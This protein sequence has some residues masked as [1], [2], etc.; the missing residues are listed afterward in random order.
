M[1][2]VAHLALWMIF[3]VGALIIVVM[4]IANARDQARRARARQALGLIPGFEHTLGN[5]QAERVMQMFEDTDMRIARR[6]PSLT[7]KQRAELARAVIV[8]KGLLAPTATGGGVVGPPT[9]SNDSR[10]EGRRARRA[11]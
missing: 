1:R 7:P 4:A 9:A 3:A 5:V 11:A 10:R 8:E 2:N 6:S